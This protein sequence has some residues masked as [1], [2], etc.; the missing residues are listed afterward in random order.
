VEG[1]DF[2]GGGGEMKRVG[3]AV[4]D[5]GAV[6]ILSPPCLILER[7][8]NLYSFG[9]DGRGRLRRRHK[10]RKKLRTARKAAMD[11]TATAAFR[12]GPIPDLVP[13]EDGLAP[14]VLAVRFSSGNVA[15]VADGVRDGCR[16]EA[17][18][19]DGGVEAGLDAEESSRPTALRLAEQAFFSPG[20]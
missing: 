17:G 7:R 10:Q 13:K 20:W 6:V 14:S 15:P 3:E 4:K 12:P 9:A 2:G 1:E 5:D 16:D 11:A 19:V 8:L 18:W